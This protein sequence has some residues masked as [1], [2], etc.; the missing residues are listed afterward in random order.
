[1]D[2]SRPH[3]IPTFLCIGRCNGKEVCE[4]NM[5][6]VRTSDPCSSTYKYLDTTYSCFPAVH[7]VTCQESLAYLQC[8]DGQLISVL[9]AFYG[10]SDQSTCIYGPPTGEVQNVQCHYAATE[11]AD[12]CNDRSS[13]SVKA[14]DSVFNDLCSAT[15][16]YLEVS[17][18]C[19]CK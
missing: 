2:A 16:K 12:S 3:L 5:N 18:I 9:G 19:K 13:C 8:D 1:M 14:A 6:V 15:Y 17:Y 4:I 7:S 10:R 11:V